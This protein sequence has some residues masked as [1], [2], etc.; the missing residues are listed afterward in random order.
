MPRE[1]ICDVLDVLNCHKKFVSNCHK[2]KECNKSDT[3]VTGKVLND[4]LVHTCQMPNR[5]MQLGQSESQ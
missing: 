5:P 3:S 2:E 1:I 4:I